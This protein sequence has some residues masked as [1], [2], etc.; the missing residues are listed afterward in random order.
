[1]ATR[2]LVAYDF[3]DCAD[4]ALEWAV[5][6]AHARGDRLTLLTVVP[7]I[8]HI[9]VATLPIVMGVE[10][11]TDERLSA[12]AQLRLLADT[13]CPEASVEAVVG[14]SEADTIVERADAL[15]ADLIVV[16]TH[17]RGALGRVVLG[18]VATKVV[19]HAHCPV[20]VVRRKTEHR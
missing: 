10:P 9:P 19:Q 13:R 2:V 14:A 15:D 18:S 20:V 3:S 4:R 12:E 5:E 11:A 17:G 7:A 8:A 16:G 6:L 1:M